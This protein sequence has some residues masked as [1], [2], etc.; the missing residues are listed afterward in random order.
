MNEKL[1]NIFGY[2]DYRNFLSDYQKT[3]ASFDRKFTKS[4]ICRLLGLPNT[5]SFFNDVLNGRSLS[6]VYVERF[7]RLFEFNQEEAQFFRILVKFN[8]ADNTEEREI[9]FDQLVSLNRTP[10]MIVEQKAYEYYKC[11]YNSTIRA[12]L[13][14]SRFKSDDYKKLTK[15][16]WPQITLKQA[17]MALELLKDLGLVTP[18]SEGNLM[19]TDKSISTGAYIRDEMI[20]QYQLQCLE[21]AKKAVIRRHKKPQ[22][23]STN[24][25]SIS[26]N[27]YRRIEKKLQRFKSEVRSI[28][29]KDEDPADHVYQLNIQLFPNSN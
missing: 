27:A 26:D 14:T 7:V 1:P 20:K 2:N 28:V 22:N 16:I 11:W 19:L 5:R 13:R 23:I 21:L 3:R 4:A 29:Q 25:I 24:V 18:D 15:K 6:S 12:L 8:Q 17:R 10:K 9:Y